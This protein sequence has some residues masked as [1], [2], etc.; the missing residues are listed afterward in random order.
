MAQRVEQTLRLRIV[1]PQA[2]GLAIARDRLRR[3]PETA[4]G[5]AE[6]AMGFGKARR[7]PQGGP[8][9]RRCV[10]RLVKAM[11]PVHQAAVRVMDAPAC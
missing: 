7:E 2:Q 1:R 10:R 8:V 4:Q 6:V 5:G 9:L 11:E 3:M